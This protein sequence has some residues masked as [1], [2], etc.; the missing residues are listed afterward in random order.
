MNRFK[1]VYAECLEQASREYPDEYWWTEDLTVRG[2]T[3]NT[4]YPKQ[5]ATQVAEKMFES[6]DRRNFNKDGRAFRMACKRLGIP[7]TYK[8]INSVLAEGDSE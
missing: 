8:A 3:G 4:V 5:T 7:H 1:K 2:N 6:M